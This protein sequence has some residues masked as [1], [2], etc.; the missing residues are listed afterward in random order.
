MFGAGPPRRPGKWTSTATRAASPGS[1]CSDSRRRRAPRFPRVTRG[2]TARVGAAASGSP[3]RA[4]ASR[5]R[6]A[7]TSGPGTLTVSPP[8]RTFSPARAD[9]QVLARDTRFDAA[10]PRPRHTPWSA[11][12]SSSCSRLA[13]LCPCETAAAQAASRRTLAALAA[14]QSPPV[15]LDPAAHRPRMSNTL[16]TAISASGVSSP[17]APGRGPQSRRWASRRVMASYDKN[18][19]RPPSS[20][21]NGSRLKPPRYALRSPSRRVFCSALLGGAAGLADDA[22][23]SGDLGLLTR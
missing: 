11:R 8:L 7:G 14:V 20:A 9:E 13:S 12:T 2:L 6:A 5:R 19:S 1:R 15:E 18:I 16:T 22:D 21:G 10:L 3:A 4:P 17:T 23:R